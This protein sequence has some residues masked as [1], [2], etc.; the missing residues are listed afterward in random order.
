MKNR[1]PEIAERIFSLLISQKDREY[2]FGEI[3]REYKEKYTAKGRISASLWYWGQLIKSLP[4]IIND[5]FR[6]NFGM[7]KN[8]IKIAFR[9]MRRQKLNTFISVFGLALS[10]ACCIIILIWVTN[11]LSFDRFHEKSERIYRI[12]NR[13]QV[14][15]T[16]VEYCLSPAPLA[17]TLKKDYPEVEECVRFFKFSEVEVEHGDRVIYE[18]NIL[19]VDSTFFK[20]FS[21]PL[22]SGN[23]GDVLNRPMTIV[24]TKSTSE[25]Y[26]GT[27]DPIGKALIVNKRSCIVTGVVEDAPQNSHFDFDFLVSLST[28]GFS[29]SEVWLS[30]DFYTYITLREASDPDQ[31]SEKLSEIVMKYAIDDYEEWSSNGNY[32]EFYLQPIADI[33]L[34]SHLGYEFEV[35][36]NRRYVHIFIITA[37]FI[38]VIA[39]INYIN[40]FNAGFIFKA[41]DICMRKIAGSKN[42]Q[43]FQQII[44]ESIILSVVSLAAGIIIVLSFQSIYS[45]ITGGFLDI[46]LLRNIRIIFGFLAVSIALGIITG[47][48]PAAFILSVKPVSVLKG[49]FFSGNRRGR[50]KDLL[51]GFQF[52]ISV[53]LI[54]NILFISKQLK[55]MQEENLGFDK[56]NVIILKNP[57]SMGDQIREFKNELLNHSDIISASASYSLPGTDFAGTFFYPEEMETK[58]LRLWFSDSDLAN[59]LKLRLISGNFPVHES[60]TENFGVIINEKAAE[61]LGWEQPLGKRMGFNWRRVR[62]YVEIIGVVENFHFESMRNEVQPLVMTPFLSPSDAPRYLSVRINSDNLSSA[63]EF[64]ENTWNRF[65]PGSD[66]SYSFLDM[67]YEGIYKNEEG[68]LNTLVV[69][70]AISLLISCMGLYGLTLFTAK[71]KTKEIGIRKVLGSSIPKL[72]IMLSKSFIKT[73][74]IANMIAWPLAYYVV[75]SWLESFNYRVEVGITLFIAGTIIALIIAFGTISS[76]TVKAAAANPVDSLRYE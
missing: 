61:L 58:T 34:D 69:F 57:N 13:S 25:K 23:P 53:I 33:H 52:V 2:F 1:P 17:F 31:F 39:S 67:E 68:I 10:M 66:F 8:H 75:N 18:N 47:I 44:V 50:G 49:K 55:F 20:V 28:L 54:I 12:A 24:L 45:I 38:L 22:I 59:T 32:W 64:I 62:R 63:I 72:L 48:Y 73:I 41:K 5:H 46:G 19:A 56:E 76:Q 14:N 11:E 42:L 71:R 4:S 21:F 35:N 70:T 65:S 51:V 15:D 60:S 16:K 40:L 37:L 27:E 43:L 36:G 26:F 6:G 29:R 3:G 74:M 9:N 30:N 7:I